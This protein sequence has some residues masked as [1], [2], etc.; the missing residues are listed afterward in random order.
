M[1]GRVFNRS[2]LIS[3][4]ATSPSPSRLL[5]ATHTASRP[6]ISSSRSGKFRL[7]NIWPM[8]P[9]TD[10]PNAIHSTPET[11]VASLPHRSS[12]RSP[13]RSSSTSCRPHLRKPKSVSPRRH[14]ER[15]RSTPDRFFI[16]PQRQSLQALDA[17][18]PIY[19]AAAC[20]EWAGRFSE[21]LITEVRVRRVLLSPKG[22]LTDREGEIDP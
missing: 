12:D 5:P 4:S 19:G 2:F 18:F 15:E 17:C 8:L 14:S 9:H 11:E 13:S 20:G 10:P 16:D 3:R 7:R 21:A 22:G 6:K 1:D